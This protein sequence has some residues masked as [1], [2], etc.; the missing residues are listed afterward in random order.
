[1]YVKQVKFEGI[2]KSEFPFNLSFV[3]DMNEVTLSK[4]V[5]FITGENG[6]GKSTFLET[7]ADLQDLNMEGGS[8]NNRFS[9]VDAYANLSEAC[10]LVRY[11]AYPKD[12]YFYRAESFYNLVSDLDH[13]GV[14]DEL[15]ARNLHQFSRGESLKELISKRFFGHGLYLLDEPETGLSLQSQ[16]EVL[17]MVH[18]LVQLDSQF[19]IC[20]HSPI[21]L[22]Y[23]D[24]D[25]LEFSETG[26]TAVAQEESRVIQQWDMIFQRKEAFFD[27]LFE[28]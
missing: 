12:M 14:S 16:L 28:D 11:P 8:R 7:I 18:D 21:L 17:V 9:T 13:L 5:T 3:R 24:A 27:Q 25:I 19:I 15:F 23:P 20:T 6:S 22:M 2:P 10:R 26:I 4:N 1:M